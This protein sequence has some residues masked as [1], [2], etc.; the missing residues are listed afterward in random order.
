MLAE[1]PTDIMMALMGMGVVVRV[2]H[3][4]RDYRFEQVSSPDADR[5]TAPQAVDLNRRS[6]EVALIDG[7]FPVPNYS[8]ALPTEGATCCAS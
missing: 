3:L 4:L 1:S 7:A 2:R 6:F 8:T 5:Q